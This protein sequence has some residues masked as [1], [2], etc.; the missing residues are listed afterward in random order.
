[1]QD[2]PAQDRPRTAP[3]RGGFTRRLGRAVVWA[4]LSLVLI[5]GLLSSAAYLMSGRPVDLPV[6]AVAELQSRVNT[7]LSGQARLSLGGVSLRIG[8]DRLPELRIEDLR[9]AS[10]EGTGRAVLP[11]VSVRFEAGS[12]LTG[13]IRPASVRISG[14]RLAL[15]RLPDGT[16]DLDIGGG[17][18]SPP[19]NF[20]E[21]LDRI[22]DTFSLPITEALNRAEADAVTITLDDRRAGRVYTVGDGRIALSRRGD[23]VALDVGMGLVGGAE[24]QARAQLTFI[25]PGNGGAEIS[26]RV[27]DMAAADL[28]AQAPVLAPLRALEA[29]ISGEMQAGLGADGRVTF[30]SGALSL[31]EGVLKPVEGVQPLRLRGAE[32]EF[33]LDPAASRLRI[34]EL[35]VDSPALR[36]RAAGHVD[37]L[38]LKDG[39][40]QDFVTQLALSDLVI[41]PHGVF[42]QSIQFS[43]GAA[44]VRLRL[45]PFSVEVG[46]FSL[47]EEDRHLSL[48]GD[49]RATDAGWEVAVDVTQDRIRH[50][51]LIALW[52]VQL[53]AK[54]REWLVENVQQGMLFNARA[55][56]RLRPGQEPRLSLGYE[57]V[58][59]D[60]RFMP[61][62]PPIRQGRGYAVIEGAS[63]VTVVE[64][65]LITPPAGGE[66]RVSR[67]MFKVADFRRRPVLAEIRLNTESS[68]TAGLSLLDQPPFGFL[69]R[70]NMPTDLGEGRA[71]ITSTIHVPLMRRPLREDIR[72]DVRGT[73]TDVRSDRLV[74]GRLVSADRLELHAVPEK[75]EIS[76]DLRLGA[77]RAS[78][79]WSMPIGVPGAGSTLKGRAR[80]DEGLGRE[81][82]AG[83]G[84]GV[85]SGAGS[86]DFEVTL[87]P[88]AL[89]A[90]Q[91][92]SDLS[93]A[94]LRLAPLGWSKAASAR[95]R[96]ELSGEIGQPLR[97]DRLHLSAPGLSAT[98]ALRLT[99]AGALER[100]TLSDLKIGEWLDASAELVGQGR[101]VAPQ[102]RVT[103]GSFDLRRLPDRMQGGAGGSGGAR[104]PI[105]VSLDEARVA[106]DIRLSQI[107]GRIS[108]GPG[109][110][111]GQL[112]ARLGGQVPIGLALAAGPGGT[113]VRLQAQDGGAALRAAGLFDKAHGGA[114]DVV[115]VPDG[116]RGHYRG[117]MS[118]KVF[119][120]RNLPALAEMLNAVS[121]IG[122]IDQLATSGIAF[123]EASGGFR[124]TPDGVELNEMS[125]VGASFGVSLEGVYYTTQDRLNLRGVISPF[126]MVNAIGSVLTRP[127]EGLVGFTYRIEGPA[128]APRVSV[129][130]L[131]ALVP[132]FL[133]DMLRR[134]AAKLPG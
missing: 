99:E 116:A 118:M 18:V 55:G 22:A 128:R 112:T 78:A 109:G 33:A 102:I 44:D 27:E 24:R 74:R 16:F 86:A 38:D 46:Q 129:N 119:V 69:S 68:L 80:L 79:T 9:I 20:A 100:L 57:F 62:L 23:R 127:G 7:A 30:L 66:I 90:L 114:L 50:N 12:L 28:A 96:L 39:I 120:V 65:G 101:G 29:P 3:R 13:K 25:I 73:L 4:G 61:T 15:R 47:V 59:A 82:L 21:L 19:E 125:A 75:V 111:D 36:M 92:R 97:I 77:A 113:S 105:T 103:G 83:L 106:G 42:E 60:V 58:D 51:Q 88:G 91:V 43:K 81:F 45:D 104:T 2:E 95:G 34:S 26:V 64:D 87:K 6:W 131:T 41:N 53:V 134:P 32:F 48:S 130:P 110:V 85:L 40:P 89:P 121:I 63:Y 49:V 93:G 10:A 31:G 56:L 54:T 126:Y 70:A 35:R 132:G 52:P 5:L 72:F 123:G 107:R 11:D 115:V 98:G 17:G 1:M 67:S 108:T 94:V 71:R 76:G 124:M 84:D 8:S 117:Q 133:R 37:L 122:L 14:A